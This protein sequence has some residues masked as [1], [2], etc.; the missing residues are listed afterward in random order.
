MLNVEITRK[1]SID[2]L[3]VER[4]V[5]KWLPAAGAAVEGQAKLYA[6]VDT[7]LLR[8]SINHRVEGDTAIVGTNVEYAPYQEYGT[9]RFRPGVGQPFMRPAIDVLRK[10]LVALLGKYYDTE[11]KKTAVK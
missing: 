2:P 9:R 3:A 8:G 1:G 10:K 4:A 11:V 5:K 7:G 6:P